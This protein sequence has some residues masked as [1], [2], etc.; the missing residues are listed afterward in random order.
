MSFKFTLLIKIISFLFFLFSGIIWKKILVNE[1]KNY[2]YIFFRVTATLFF[3]LLIKFY[4]TINDIEDFNVIS[5]PSYYDWV[6]CIVTCLFSFWGLYFYTQALQNGRISFITSL[7]GIS[8]FFSFITSIILFN[9]V[10][11]ISKYLSLI[12][13]L[14]GL[15]LHQRDKWREFTISK[16]VFYTLMF[17]IIWGISFV[18]FLIPIKVFGVLN[19]SII[20]EVCVFASCIGLLVFKDKRIIP[21][22]LTD[23]HLWLCLFMGFL[24]AGGSLLSN[25][26]LTLFPVSLNILLGLVFEVIVL[27]IG[28]Y[29]FREKLAKKD[30]ILIGITTVCSVLLLL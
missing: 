8:P 29:F 20:L 18:L 28:L 17:T 27:A 30:W 26:T 23:Q 5:T 1:N 16:E 2:H 3:L 10:L 22:K 4:F 9:E 12:L 21:P 7:N 25:F 6:I 15:F 19:F 13:I 14:I 24:V 11:N